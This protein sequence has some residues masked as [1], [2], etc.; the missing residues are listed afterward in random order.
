MVAA[1]AFAVR[2]GA[3]VGVTGFG[4]WV[5]FTASLTVTAQVALFNPSVAVI[6]AVPAVTAVILPF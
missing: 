3:G 6:V 1:C 5:G 2:T 4:V